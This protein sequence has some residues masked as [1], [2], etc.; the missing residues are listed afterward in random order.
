MSKI[1]NKYYG[2]KNDDTVIKEIIITTILI[3]DNCHTDND[4]LIIMI[5]DNYVVEIK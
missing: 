1:D 4:E 2:K 5:N 3:T